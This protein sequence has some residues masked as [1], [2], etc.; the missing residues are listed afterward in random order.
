VLYVISVL[1]I[2]ERIPLVPVGKTGTIQ[3]DIQRESA[4][5][6]SE[7]IVALC[8]ATVTVE[9]CSLDACQRV[10]T[11]NPSASKIEERSR[12]AV[13]DRVGHNFREEVC[14]TGSDGGMSKACPNVLV[15]LTGSSARG[16]GFSACT[17]WHLQ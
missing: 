6:H 10:S 14:S 17:L 4:D 5:R 11:F 13:A 15:E 2:L 7:P 12:T 8:Y 9:D 1:S 16:S 3:F